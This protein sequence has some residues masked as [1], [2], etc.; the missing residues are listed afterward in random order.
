MA[1]RFD[2]LNRIETKVR[3][4]E[5]MSTVMDVAGLH[6]TG[7]RLPLGVP[8]QTVPTLRGAEAAETAGTGL[9][10]VT[11]VAG[12]LVLR[13]GQGG[14]YK[15]P[16]DPVMSVNSKNVIVRRYVAKGS[17]QGS[18]KESWSQD[19]FEVTIAG[20]LI[21]E[22]GEDL[23]EQISDLRAVCESGEVLAVENDWLNDGF[24]IYNVVV[25]SCQFPHTKGALN[26]SYTLKLWSDSSVNILEEVQ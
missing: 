9:G 6:A 25:E 12:T 20:V 26:Q 18:V 13:W 21:G 4:L 23:R 2:P 8:F 15:F 22:S 19:D 14:F 7:Y 1:K 5:G 11:N 10:N 3:G 17:V 24:G 16:L